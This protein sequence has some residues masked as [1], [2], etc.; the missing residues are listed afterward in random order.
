MH[1]LKNYGKKSVYLKVLN[2]L[3]KK[4]IIC[5]NMSIGLI[6][7]LKQDGMLD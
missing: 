5:L 6:Q 4:D 7:E 3:K 1:Q 2:Q